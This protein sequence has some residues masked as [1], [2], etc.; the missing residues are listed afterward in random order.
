MESEFYKK[1]QEIIKKGQ[2]YKIEAYEFIMQA[3]FYTQTKLKRQGHVTGKELLEGIK[4]YGIEQFGALTQ[5]VFEQWG[6]RKTEDFGE[7]VFNLVNN[8]LLK[9]TE[10]DSIEDFKGVYKFKETFEAEH[11]RKFL[12][13]IKREL[14]ISDDSKKKDNKKI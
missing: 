9:R 7:I 13:D 10:E 1:V 8:G 6:I 12:E 11:R 3:L 14:D 5:T 4:E 2:R